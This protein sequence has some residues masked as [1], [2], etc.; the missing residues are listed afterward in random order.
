MCGFLRHGLVFHRMIVLKDMEVHRP[1][2]QDESR[3][4]CPV[5]C[6]VFGPTQQNASCAQRISH[7]AMVRCYEAVHCSSGFFVAFTRIL[8]Y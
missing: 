1:V 7:M 3:D 6:E 2:I 8:E 5:T 4:I